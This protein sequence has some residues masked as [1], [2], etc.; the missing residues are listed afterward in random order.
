[1]PDGVPI[2]STEP[3]V[4]SVDTDVLLRL[5]TDALR[6][7]PS[8][9]EWAEAVVR[10]NAVD[11]DPKLDEYAVLLAVRDRLAAGRGYRAV[12]AGP[13][14]GRRL[15]TRVD[16]VAAA[17]R[18]QRSPLSANFFAVL[19]VGAVVGV[20][21]ILLSVLFR[22]GS[23][24]VP[25]TSDLATA[26]FAHPFATATLT[27]TPPP[28]WRHVGSLSLEDSR[29]L[30]LPA[31]AKL[32][33]NYA[34]GGLVT[35]RA[36]PADEPLSVQ[37]TF[38]FGP[39]VGAGC[40]PQVFVSDTP[41]FSG[42]RG[43]STHELVWLVQDGQGRVAP[44]DGRVAGPQVRV[45]GDETV[46]VVVAPDGQAAVVC[47]KQVLWSGASGLG[48]DRPRYAGVRLLYRSPDGRRDA[49]T[50]TSLEVLRR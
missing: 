50:V 16:A 21:G 33:D 23:P 12:R 8:S 39:H 14:F 9:P 36:V 37:A 22:S 7:G 27:D 3:D 24:E 44:A 5:L 47:N 41:D 11:H 28:G 26:Y 18:P 32:T 25:A 20:V 43:V 40:V 48:V 6:S 31:G 19:G 4:E 38:H 30:A 1:M 10:A 29:R 34:G 13:G 45:G 2:P 49:V 35:Q 46:K 42:D 17:A 15:M